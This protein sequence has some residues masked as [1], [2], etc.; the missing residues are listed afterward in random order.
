MRFL[1]LLITLFLLSSCNKVYNHYDVVNNTSKDIEVKIE[2]YG[3]EHQKYISY[4]IPSGE[5][6]FVIEHPQIQGSEKSKDNFLKYIKNIEIVTSDS[7]KKINKKFTTHNFNYSESNGFLGD[8]YVWEF[9]IEESD[10][11]H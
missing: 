4:S 5:R 7:N 11:E 2:T 9:V 3:G 8:Y 1:I 10:I 6:E